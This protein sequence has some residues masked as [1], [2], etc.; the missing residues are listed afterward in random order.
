MSTSKK[1]VQLTKKQLKELKET[2]Q[3]ERERLTNKLNLDHPHH[4][5]NN[6]DSGKDEVDS[7]NDD[8]LRRSEMRFAT[9]EGFYLKKLTKTLGLMDNEEY[10][11]CEDCGSNIS[12]TRLKARPTSTMCIGCK[13][14]SERNEMQNYH[15]RMSKSLGKS[16]SFSS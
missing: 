6:S 11:I 15:G 1:K 4:T 9:R 3:A 10:G 16:V 2:V 13:E 14:E 5:I 8:I 12:F 7:A